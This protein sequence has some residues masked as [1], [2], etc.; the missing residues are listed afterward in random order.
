[1]AK[2]EYDWA[3]VRLLRVLLDKVAEDEY[4]SSYMMD[5][6]EELLLPQELPVYARLLLR[7]IESAQFPSIDLIHRLRNL[8]PR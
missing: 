1:M 2:D 7:R 5:T 4:P 3:R 6:I 8:Q